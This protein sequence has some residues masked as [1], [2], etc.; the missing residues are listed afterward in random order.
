MKKKLF[1]L[2]A[3]DLL[4]I[5][6]KLIGLRKYIKKEMLIAFILMISNLQNY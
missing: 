3:K 6:S 5:F 1:F 4:Q 2:K